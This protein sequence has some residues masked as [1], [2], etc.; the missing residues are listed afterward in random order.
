MTSTT[1]LFT[2][3][4][5]TTFVFDGVMTVKVV[6]YDGD[7]LICVGLNGWDDDHVY[8]FTANDRADLS[9]FRVLENR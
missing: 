2:P 9:Q 7:S 5:G 6:R 8:A 1:D 4:P 3:P